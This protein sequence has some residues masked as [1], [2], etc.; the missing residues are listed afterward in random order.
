MGELA[1]EDLGGCFEELGEVNF[2]GKEI[3]K[4][5]EFA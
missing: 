4:A 3:S 2:L 5:M 1:T